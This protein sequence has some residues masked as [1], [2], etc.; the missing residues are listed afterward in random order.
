MGRVAELGS[1]GKVVERTVEIFALVH[2]VI[3]GASHAVR[4]DT[5]AEMFVLLAKQGRSGVFLHG[6]LSLWFGSIIAGFYR[7]YTG[8]GLVLT[9]FGWLVTLK[10]LHC[11]CFPAAALRS[12]QRVSIE[13]SW[14][15]IPVGI[16]YLLVAC[17]IGY[18]LVAIK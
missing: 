10:A 9:V 3:L 18:R 7:V 2:L 16:V 13:T 4:H 5:W 15:F 6:F 8:S 11:F 1:L 12:L 14:K 17:V